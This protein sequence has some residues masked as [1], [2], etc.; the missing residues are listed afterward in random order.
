MAAIWE[1]LFVWYFSRA[2]SFSRY[3]IIFIFSLVPTH[4]LIW[5]HAPKRDCSL[6]SAKEEYQT[7]IPCKAPTHLPE[8]PQQ[9]SQHLCNPLPAGFWSQ[10]VPRV[11]LYAWSIEMWRQW[12]GR[13]ST[14][15]K[16]RYHSER[17][18][19]RLL[20]MDPSPVDSLLRLLQLSVRLRFDR[21]GR[22][23]GM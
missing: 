2:E 15:S 19:S 23:R 7:P 8:R 20:L 1:P 14:K 10:L 18:Q 17:H 12:A 4:V 3:T 6:R 9:R 22:P 16:L 21:H 13:T 11:L 5:Q